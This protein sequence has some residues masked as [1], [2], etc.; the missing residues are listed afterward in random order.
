MILDVVLL[1][2]DACRR[3]VAAVH[4]SSRVVVVF[5][6]SL[7]PSVGA[8]TDGAGPSMEAVQTGAVGN[9]PLQQNQAPQRPREPPG[10]TRYARRRK[11]RHSVDGAV[12]IMGKRDAWSVTYDDDDGGGGG[13]G[14]AEGSGG[15]GGGG[16]W[17]WGSSGA[18]GGRQEGQGGEGCEGG[19]LP[20]RLSN[21]NVLAPASKRYRQF[22][23]GSSGSS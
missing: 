3:L 7:D 16:G 8:S 23:S 2:L 19:S 4:M 10:S 15:G 14:N 20:L 18:N 5:F 1:L 21:R 22:V 17:R 6:L 11:R 13:D 12:A 9:L